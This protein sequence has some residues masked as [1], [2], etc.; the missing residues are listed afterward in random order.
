MRL[1]VAATPSIA[2]PALDYLRKTREISF[3]ITQPDKPTG[4]GQV[5]KSSE[6]AQW[7]SHYGIE[8]LKPEKIATIAER[9]KDIDVVITI[10]YGQLVPE[11]VLSL[12]RFG[13]INLH[14]SLLP[15]WRG[16]APVQRSLLAGD[17]ITGVSVFHLDKGMDTGPIYSQ[18]SLQIERNWRSYEL[19]QALN[20]LGIEAIQESLEMIASGDA[21]RE[22]VGLP[23][24]APKILK[25]EYQLDFNLPA[26]LLIRKIKALYPSAFL[27]FA[28]IRLKITSAHEGGESLKPVGE[29]VSL[30]P[31]T[32]TCGES[33]TIIIESL[34]PEG[35][36]EMKAEE[37]INGARLHI[38]DKFA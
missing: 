16:A 21:P 24:M 29:I 25:E 7:G 20:K 26:E 28:G 17:R 27:K 2:I 36:R 12:P 34:V 30:A 22:Q 19:Y 33:T 3:I 14:Y 37:W 15:S 8:V 18:K 5:M 10:A 1:A 13:F 6:V 4:R 38:G 35:K 32:I 11:I 23:S 9:L 31:L